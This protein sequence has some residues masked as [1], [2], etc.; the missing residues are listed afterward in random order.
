MVTGFVIF[1]GT[2]VSAQSS[3]VSTEEVMEVATAEKTIAV[4]VKGVGC[5]R[6]CKAIATNVAGLE[7]VSNCETVKKGATTTFS[8]TYN[9]TVATETMIYSAVENT[10]G[11]SKQTAKPYKVKL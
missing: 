10:A 5:S 3:T 9:P 11:C 6:D 8:V 7:G 4:K 2:L 1:G